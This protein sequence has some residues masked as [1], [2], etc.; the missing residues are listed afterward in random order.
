MRI[1]KMKKSLCT[2]AV[3]CCLALSPAVADEKNTDSYNHEGYIQQ[4]KM[5]DLT[6]EYIDCVGS[7]L[8][9]LHEEGNFK[10]AVKT[11]DYYVDI[12]KKYYGK[13]NEKLFPAYM[14]R[15]RLY[16]DYLIPDKAFKDLENAQALLKWSKNSEELKKQLN[17]EYVEFYSSVKQYYDSIDYLEKISQDL[18]HKYAYE[19]YLYH[20]AGD[21]NKASEYSKKALKEASVKADTNELMW[22]YCEL[23]GRSIPQY[24]LKYID[25]QNSLADSLPYDNA[26]AKIGAKIRKLQYFESMN[27][28]VE[29]K[30]MLDAVAAS[31][32][33]LKNNEF[34]VPLAYLYITYYSEKGDHN[35]VKKY[36]KIL[37]K[38]KQPPFDWSK[39]PSESLKWSE[40]YEQDTDW[41]NLNEAQK[42]VN[43]A[44]KQIEPVKKYVPLFYS[45][46]LTRAAQ[47]S[48][49]KRDFKLA[50]EYLSLAEKALKKPAN[51]PKFQ[52]AELYNTY[53]EYYKQKGEFET[54]LNYL[55]K[56]LD[57]F[58]EIRKKDDYE[59][60]F[61]YKL[62]A[63]VYLLMDKKDKFDE[64]MEKT[65]DLCK[66]VYGE[67]HIHTYENMYYIYTDYKHA[68]LEKADTILDSIIDAFDNN[69]VIGNNK[70]IV[71]S[72]YISKFHD[73]INKGD[74]ENAAK[75]GEKAIKYAVENDWKADTYSELAYVY[76]N[77]GNKAMAEKYNKMKKSV[78]RK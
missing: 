29:N 4:Y 27:Q 47:I 70:G 38:H 71:Y 11:A 25:M 14:S 77:L 37:D 65:I 9:R 62:I 54:A 44:L 39:V 52:K 36:Q 15:A 60:L 23:A 10:E 49:A 22:L 18:V 69:K 66:E 28:L 43:N 45:R 68:G 48:I 42:A 64:Y 3:I 78:Q 5:T 6:P 72:V 20:R 51:T 41:G 46:F 61:Q 24:A 59:L 32:S 56:S 33:K 67:N 40:K 30:K 31:A 75:Y 17:Y 12:S 7:W 16:R 21:T 2:I 26:N 63:G 13:H 74:F 34:E 57:I 50:D 55:N 76:S 53:A 35:M 73:L 1:F 19:A 58:K 8:S